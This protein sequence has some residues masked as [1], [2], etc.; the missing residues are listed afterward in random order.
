MKKHENKFS[1]RAFAILLALALCMGMLP[2]TAVAVDCEHD[3]QG[4]FCVKVSDG[5]RCEVKH[6]HAPKCIYCGE[7]GTTYWTSHG[8]NLDYV[9]T[10]KPQDDK[11]H[12]VDCK[13]CTYVEVVRHTFSEPTCTAPATCIC[14]ATEGEAL[15]HDFRGT[16]VQVG[17]DGHAQMCVYSCGQRGPKEPHTPDELKSAPTAVWCL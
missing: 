9:N 7:K 17:T 13:D 11:L 14:G 12:T 6:R 10:I 5:S 4:D 15:E 3:F 8:H 1:K 2:F 16:W